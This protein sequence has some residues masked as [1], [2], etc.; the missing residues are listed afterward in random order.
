[1]IIR[2]AK[3][4]AYN[5]PLIIAMNPVIHLKVSTL[6]LVLQILDCGQG[7]MNIILGTCTL[8]SFIII[9][10]KHF[11]QNIIQFTE[12]IYLQEH[13]NKCDTPQLCGEIG[14]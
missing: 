10:V 8:D 1:M 14:R 6:G 9:H 5:I 4:K 7:N 3:V 2:L 12:N 13:N 11:K